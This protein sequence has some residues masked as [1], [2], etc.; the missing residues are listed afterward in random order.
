MPQVKKSPKSRKGPCD[1]FIWLMTNELG[2][3]AADLARR[4][5]YANSTTVQK[6]KRYETFPDVDRLQKLSGLRNSNGERP[7]LDWL[8]TGEG[9]PVI[10]LSDTAVRTGKG[11]KG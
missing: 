5:G 9:K 1:R 4:L 7:N 8:I 3:R 11:G 2:L 10:R 6:V